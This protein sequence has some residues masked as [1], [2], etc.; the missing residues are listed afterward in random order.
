M[1]KVFIVH[2]SYEYE[3]MFVEAG[4]ELAD[5]LADADLVQ[6]TGGEDVSPE[7]YGQRN[8]QSYVNVKRDL[9]DICAFRKALALS[10]PMAGICRGGQ[11]LNVMSGGK[12]IQHVEGHATGQMHRA[13]DVVWN[14]FENVLVTSTHHQ[15]MVPGDMGDIL[16]TANIVGEEDTEAVYY[17]HTQCLCF[18][19]HP[20]F[21]EAVGDCRD[22]YFRYINHFFHL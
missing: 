6:F 12:M 14:E 13:E 2:S 10:I 5:S 4:W 20:E 15:M 3:R 16:L 11:F 1:K 9:M 7:L 18:Q 22:L 17:T 8:T 21:T 19:P